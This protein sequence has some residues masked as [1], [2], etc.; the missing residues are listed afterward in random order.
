VSEGRPEEVT[1]RIFCDR[2]GRPPP[3]YRDFDVETLVTLTA[4][5]SSFPETGLLKER[6]KDGEMYYRFDYSIE[7]TYLSAS[8]K[9]EMI[10]NGKLG[11]FQAAMLSLF[12]QNVAKA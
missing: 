2:T 8:T 1:T 6:G 4:D 11:P 10:H 9:Y 3:R 5:I 7:V 12:E